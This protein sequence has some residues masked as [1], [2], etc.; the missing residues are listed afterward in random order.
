MQKDHGL[1]QAFMVD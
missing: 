1:V